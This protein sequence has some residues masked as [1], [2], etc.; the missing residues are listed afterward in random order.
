MSLS[1][2]MKQCSDSELNFVKL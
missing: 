1:H 2:I